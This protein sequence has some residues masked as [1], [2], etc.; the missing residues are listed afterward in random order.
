MTYILIDNKILKCFWVFHL[1]L[2]LDQT[3]INIQK[4]IELQITKTLNIST[5]KKYLD[6]RKKYVYKHI[7]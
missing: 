1:N 7:I 5:Q 3:N 2:Y 6:L 4:T